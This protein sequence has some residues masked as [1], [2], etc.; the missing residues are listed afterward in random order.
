MHLSGPTRPKC[1]ATNWSTDG[2]G[3][4]LMQK[5]CQCLKKT[6]DCCQN[7]WKLCLVGS[8]FNLPAESWYAPIEGETFAVVYALHQTRYYVLGC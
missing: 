6:P 3:F 7:G 8:R 5:Y 2:L 1:L 4:F